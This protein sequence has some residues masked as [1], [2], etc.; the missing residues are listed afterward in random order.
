MNGSLKPLDETLPADTARYRNAINAKPLVSIPKT[1][2]ETRSFR[3]IQR[4]ISVGVLSCALIFAGIG[5]LAATTEL[6]GAVVGFGH[7][8][9][10]SSVKRVQHLTGGIVAEIHARDGDVVQAGQLLVKLDE[11]VLRAELDI[12]RKTYLQA[13]ARA[14]RLT[15]ERD[16]AATIDFQAFL[17]GEDDP[18]LAETIAG[19]QRLFEARVTNRDIQV[20]QI[21]EQIRQVREQIAGVEQ[22]IASADAQITLNADELDGLRKLYKKKMVSIVRLNELEREQAQLI[23][24]RG[25]LVTD[26]AAL[27]ARAAEAEVRIAVLQQDFRTTASEELRKVQDEA[28]LAASRIVQSVDALK[29]VNVY[30]P[31]DGVV[32]QSTVHT[33][34]GIVTPNVD[35]MQIVPR[36]DKLVV[37]ARISPADIDQIYPGQP[38]RVRF[39]AFD[40]NTTPELHAEVDVVAADLTVDQTTGQ[41]YFKVKLRIPPEEVERLG[42]LKLVPGMPAESYIHTSDRTIFSYLFK[43]ITDQMSRAFREG[44]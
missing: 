8:V 27:R 4:T 15:A 2:G 41:G 30:A 35:L 9:V 16:G 39:S 6:A 34:G 12:A 38:S 22:Q 36:D 25:K 33:I 3:Q 29:R 14:A 11:T 40:R 18:S 19:E 5:T 24:S 17:K 44:G 20:Q 1:A 21:G 10:D 28:N 32:H 26:T 42:D 23:G 31:V 13:Q 37:E 7:V 43:P